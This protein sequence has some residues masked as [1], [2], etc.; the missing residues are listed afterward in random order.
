[1]KRVRF[2]SFL[3][4][5]L[6]CLSLFPASAFAEG[7]LAEAPAE[8]FE[9]HAAAELPEEEAL[10]EEA[11]AP[12]EELP[13]EEA[14]ELEAPLPLDEEAF[15]EDPFVAEEPQAAPAPAA[16][17]QDVNNSGACGENLSWLLDEQGTL[18]ISGSGLMWSYSESNRP[19]WAGGGKTVVKALVV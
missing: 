10:F 6:M 11:S 5:V 7:E 18:T 19:G 17:P 3:L 4:C 16:E 12:D 9:E 15:F 1:M 8:L 13:G 14:P 2:L